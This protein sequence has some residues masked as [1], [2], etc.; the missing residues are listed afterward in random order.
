MKRGSE[1]RG[2]LDAWA[3]EFIEGYRKASAVRNT[4]SDR[5]A[6][7]AKLEE[8]ATQHPQIRVLGQVDVLPEFLDLLSRSESI[9][10]LIAELE[11]TPGSKTLSEPVARFIEVM[12]G[13]TQALEDPEMRIA[14]GVI[15]AIAIT[16]LGSIYENTSKAY[17]GDAGPR[18]TKEFMWLAGTTLEFLGKTF[19]TGKP[20][21]LK[22]KIN[23]ELIELIKV[24]R[25]HQT[26]KLTYR[27]LRD[28][29]QHA[30]LHVPD[31]ETLR[32]FEWRAKKKG[33]IK[34]PK[35]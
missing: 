4:L 30:G 27:E 15:S 8:I 18:E 10:S 29:L 31:E 25:Q 19:K 22:G 7:R 32:V 12:Q 14:A 24:L 13:V 35:T 2:K 34:S 11:P 20:P 21:D 9:A 5:A 26:S 23:V 33:W 17:F 3:V 28:A 1:W 16:V 6:W